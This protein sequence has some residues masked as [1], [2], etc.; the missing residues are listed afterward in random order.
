MSFHSWQYLMSLP[1]EEFTSLMTQNTTFGYHSSS[2]DEF[3]VP[4]NDRYA[5]TYITGKPGSGKSGLMENLIIS[6]MAS[7]R[8]VIEFDAHG[9]LTNNLLNHVP[10]SRQSD[11]F[12]LDME[13]E[14]WPFGV[15]VF[16]TGPL[17]T[18]AERTQ[19]IARIEHIFEVLWPD[20]LSQA[21]LPRYL[22]MA[23]H[24]FLAN[25]GTTLPDM[26][27]FLIDDAYRRKLLANVTDKNVL[28]FWQAKY[29]SLPPNTRLSKVDPLL[30]RL[31]QLFAGRTLVRNIVGQ[32]D[33]TIN[34]REAIEQR[35]IIFVKLPIETLGQDARLVGAFL[36]SQIHAAVFSFGDLPPEKR[37]GVSLYMDEFQEFATSDIERLF[38]Q[39]RKFGLRLTVAHQFR[40][41]LRLK[42]VREA[43]MTA[44]TKVCFQLTPEDG[45]ELAHEFPAP[46]AEVKPEHVDP[47]ACE[48]LLN[49]PHLHPA[50]VQEFIEWYLRPVQ[51]MQVG[52]HGN[53]VRMTDPG[54]S[55]SDAVGDL[56][57]EDDNHY[58]KRYDYPETENPLV[59]VDYLLQHVMVTGLY[60]EPIP[61]VAVRGFANCGVSFWQKVRWLDDTDKRLCAD[62]AEL[63]I[64]AYLL[65]PVPDGS[66][67][68]SRQPETAAEQLLHFLYHLRITMRY[69]AENP[70]GTRTQMSNAEVGKMLNQLPKRAAAIRNGQDTGIIFTHDTPRRLSEAAY[71]DIVTTIQMHTR[72]TYCRSRAEVEY[73]LQGTQADPPLAAPPPPQQ[74]VK[75]TNT[76]PLQHDTPSP[77][78]TLSGWEEA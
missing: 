38:T 50:V 12:V 74:A 67:A 27:D 14:D 61:A 5:G 65:T 10:E 7:G 57:F 13:D 76:R 33:N 49:H 15:N 77:Q 19:A 56:L 39:G 69:L 37:P 34:F 24:V 30:G 40:G 63:N 31:E 55:L 3:L 36:L 64:P 1:E 6:D 32:R 17:T 58:K 21:N 70:L 52:S 42:E 23:I 20:V 26:Y 47:H 71:T 22:R 54:Y 60:L 16:N 9:D 2:Y 4:N 73:A 68:W 28:Q 18:E 35:Q 59:Y 45:R 78:P 72:W 43:T 62:I 51:L 8:G 41:Q 66:Y 46:E 44:W 75:V 48:T 11:T 25:S 29:D 53:K